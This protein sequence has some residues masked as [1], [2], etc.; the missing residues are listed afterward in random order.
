MCMHGLCNQHNC[1]SCLTAHS[2]AITAPSHYAFTFIHVHSIPPVHVAFTCI[3]IHS[4]LC[5][6]RS[7][8]STFVRSVHIHSHSFTHLFTQPP[9]TAFTFPPVYAVFT[10]IHVH[11]IHVHSIQFNSI[12][13]HSSIHQRFVHSFISSCSRVRHSLY[14]VTIVRSTLAVQSERYTPFSSTLQPPA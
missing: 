13:V 6:Q 4:Y 3:H 8:H 1:C 9:F 12:H 5:T 14:P 7:F 10:C 11:S 2:I